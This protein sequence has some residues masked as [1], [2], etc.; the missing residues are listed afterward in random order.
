MN[1]VLMKFL[2]KYFKKT[3]LFAAIE[4]GD[5]NIIKLLLTSNKIDLNILNVMYYC[6]GCP[7]VTM[8]EEEEIILEVNKILIQFIQMELK[9]NYS[10]KFE[11]LILNAI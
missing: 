9:S 1:N 6:W 3:A 4:K 10:M 11:I 8:P 5:I 7:N 2:A